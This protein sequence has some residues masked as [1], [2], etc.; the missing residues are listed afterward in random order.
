M[1]GRRKEGKQRK[2]GRHVTRSPRDCCSESLAG[3]KNTLRRVGRGGGNSY[4]L[5]KNGSSLGPRKL[6]R[7]RERSRGKG[8]KFTNLSGTKINY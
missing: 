4:E 7:E 5:K 8:E 2:H 3:R 6:A 1:E